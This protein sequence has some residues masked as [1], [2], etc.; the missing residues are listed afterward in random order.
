M[1]TKDSTDRQPGDFVLIALA[2]IGMLTALA[3]V[4]VAS[5][6]A[7]VCGTFILLFVIAC[8]AVRPCP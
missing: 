8:F 4:S 5:V 6:P 2:A 3:G 7:A 1:Q